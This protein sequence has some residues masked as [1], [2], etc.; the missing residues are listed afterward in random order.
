MYRGLW[1]FMSLFVISIANL[2]SQIVIN[3]LQSSNYSTIKDEFGEFPDWVELYNNGSSTINLAGWSISDDSSLPQ[4]WVFPDITIAPDNY[5]MVFASGKDIIQVPVYWNTIL[6]AGDSVKYLVPSDTVSSTWKNSDY[7]DQNWLIGKS[8]FGYGDNDDSTELASPLVSVFLRKKFTIDNLAEVKE[9]ILNVDYDDAFAAYLNGSEVARSNLGTAG[10]S[11]SYNQLADGN[12]EAL[13][14]NGGLPE[15]FDISAHLSLLSE[16]ENVLALQF[17]NVSYT[18]SDFTAIPILTLGV[19]AI[20]GEQH[21]SRY[22]PFGSRGMHTNFKIKSDGEALMLFNSTQQLV[23]SLP[24]IA[25]GPDLSYGRLSGTLNDFSYF[26]VPTPGSEN[27]SSPLND[28]SDD[29]INFS[30]SG[31]YTSG[32]LSLTLTNA[33]GDTIYYTLDGSEPDLQS[34]KY[35]GPINITE[36][37]VVK[38]RVIKKGYLPTTVYSNTYITDRNSDLPVI[39]LSTNP[40]N[41]WDYYSGIY[42]EGPGA[43]PEIPHFG[44][45]Y[46]MEWEYPLQIEYYNTNEEKVIEQ[47][48]GVKIFG[49]WSRANAQ[50][51]L[52]LM[53]RK[54]F[55][56]AYFNY[57]F[58]KNKSL[59]QYRSVVLRNAGNDWGYSFIRDG[60]VTGITAHLG[61]DHQGFQ[62]VSTY[63][64]GEYWGM[65]NLREKVN[66]HFIALNHHLDEDEIIIL[67]GQGWPVIGDNTEYQQLVTYLNSNSSLST[68]EKYN[69]VAGQVDIDNFI[70]YQLIQIYVN[71]TD[72]PGNNIKFWKSTLPG[73]RWRYILY[74]TDFGLG[75]YNQNDYSNN[76]LGFALEPY[77]P[78]WPNPPWSTL[79]FR[80]LVTNKGFRN[81]FINQLADNINTTFQSSNFN[82]YV[83]SLKS[84]ISDEMVFHTARWGHSYDN[85]SWQVDRIKNWAQMR[86]NY[87]R[88]HIRSQFNLAAQHTI[89]LDVSNVQHG[90]IKLNTIQPHSYPFSGIYFEGVPVSIEAVP[91]QGYTFVKWEGDV[92]HTQRVFTH[93]LTSGYNIKA[94]FEP[95]GNSNINVVINEINYNSSEE[96]DAGDWVEIFNNSNSSIDIHNY[97]FN[98]LD[99]DTGFYFGANTNMAPGDFLVICKSLNKFSKVYP[100]VENV[101]GDF[102]FSLSSSGDEIRLYDPFSNVIDAVDYLP[103]NPWPLEANGTG[104]TLE[105][106]NPDLDNGQP[107]SWV[108]V[109]EGGTPGKQNSAYSGIEENIKDAEYFTG[110]KVYPNRFS[111]VTTIDINV[112]QSGNVRIEIVDIKGTIVKLICNGYLPEGQHTF[113]WEPDGNLSGGIYIIRLQTNKHNYNEKVSFIKP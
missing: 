48:G 5:V 7:T 87:M 4:K 90:R 83:D 105:L 25:V 70:K 15:T 79:L 55:G 40:A 56:E 103:Y 44:A 14:Y 24:G 109:K 93:N 68:D 84:L 92:N 27:G 98:E 96:Y 38:A 21:Q 73:S 81:N 8:G 78:G 107:E 41:L 61:V 28:L 35:A 111:D 88:N 102:N 10:S 104:A 91:L 31:G 66:E 86:P 29:I 30:H 52:A 74:D 2:S 6:D 37:T 3:E 59:E 63:L 112:K 33:S 51:S 57:P 77:G 32:Q 11:V 43:N 95:T 12:H 82:A 19:N 47:C 16:G 39:A 42:V 75:I 80:R 64:N 62:S 34:D 89:K 67:E 94:V 71:N 45:N 17:H 36:N 58:Y 100:E 113:D 72:W 108:A 54:S 65:Y 49:G 106:I 46:W 76:T 50:K 26:I 20:S 53:S 13:I 60:I 23:D 97:L 99:N 18:S 9:L 1:V 110:L 22:F 101:V 85:W 69:F